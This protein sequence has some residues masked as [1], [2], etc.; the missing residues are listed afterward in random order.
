[1]RPK[2]M[3]LIAPDVTFPS[4]LPFFGTTVLA[5]TEDKLDAGKSDHIMPRVRSQAVR[6]LDLGEGPLLVVL[7]PDCPR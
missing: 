3:N 1:M 4:T 7:R 6:N 5:S 2:V